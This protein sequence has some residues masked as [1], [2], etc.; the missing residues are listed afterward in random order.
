MASNETPQPTEEAVSVRDKE[1]W[2]LIEAMAADYRREGKSIKD[3]L[4]EDEQKLKEAI[5]SNRHIEL[6]DIATWNEYTTKRDVFAYAAGRYARALDDLRGDDELPDAPDFDQLEDEYRAA[7]NETAGEINE[8]LEAA[9]SGAFEEPELVLD[10]PLEGVPDTFELTAFASKGVEAKRRALAFHNE[11]KGS[12]SELGFTDFHS[13]PGYDDYLAKYGAYHD[14]LEQFS[15][16]DESHRG[17]TRQEINDFADSI[18]PL[19]EEAEAA[20]QAVNKE[21]VRR[22]E[23]EQVQHTVILEA[24]PKREALEQEYERISEQMSEAGI[25]TVAYGGQNLEGSQA[26][27]D[28]YSDYA[29]KLDEI[30]RVEVNVDT[31]TDNNL[32]NARRDVTKLESEYK[33][34]LQIIEDKIADAER[35]KIATD[36]PQ[37]G[38]PGNTW[39]MKDAVDPETAEAE[40]KKEFAQETIQGF[41][42]EISAMRKELQKLYG[43]ADAARNDDR[44]VAWVDRY[45]NPTRKKITALETANSEEAR[46]EIR[47]AIEELEREQRTLLRAVQEEQGAQKQEKERIETAKKTIEDLKTDA[48]EYA[49]KLENVEGLKELK[50]KFDTAADAVTLYLERYEAGRGTFEEIEGRIET[51]RGMYE[52]MERHVDDDIARSLTDAHEDRTRRERDE[53]EGEAEDSDGDPPEEDDD[54][55]RRRGGD[56]SHSSRSKGS[57]THVHIRNLHVNGREGGESGPITINIAN[58][59]EGMPRGEEGSRG[60]REAREVTVGAETFT[61]PGESHERTLESLRAWH[62]EILH[63]FARLDRDDPRWESLR[64]RMDELRDD[65]IPGFERAAGGDTPDEDAIRRHFS[66]AVNII[67][68]FKTELGI[69]GDGIPS[70]GTDAG[71]EDDGAETEPSEYGRFLEAL[72]GTAD[73]TEYLRRIREDMPEGTFQIEGNEFTRRSLYI[74]IF[75]VSEQI[76]YELL[77]NPELRNQGA[78][79]EKLAEY[80]VPDG[81]NIRQ[82]VA[83]HLIAECQ[84]Y[85]EVLLP[86]SHFITVRG[87]EMPYQVFLEQAKTN[88]QRILA[89]RA[90]ADAALTVPNIQTAF[91]EH[92]GVNQVDFAKAGVENLRQK[93]FD[94]LQYELVAETRT[95]ENINEMSLTLEEISTIEEFKLYIRSTAGIDGAY[96]SI[97]AIERDVRNAILEQAEPDRSHIESVASLAAMGDE[98]QRNKFT[99]L[100]AE[101][102]LGRERRNEIAEATSVFDLMGIVRRRFTEDTVTYNGAEYTGEQIA[103]AIRA[104]YDGLQSATL[105]DTSPL[106]PQIAQATDAIPDIDAMGIR[107]RFIELYMQQLGEAPPPHG[108]FRMANT[109]DVLYLARRTEWLYPNEPGI[110]DA[111]RQAFEAARTAQDASETPLSMEDISKLPEVQ[112]VPRKPG[113]Q[114]TAIRVIHRELGSGE[115]SLVSGMPV[116][117]ERIAAA[118]TFGD[119]DGALRGLDKRFSVQIGDNR[120]DKHEVSDAVTTTMNEVLARWRSTPDSRAHVTAADLG[121][122]SDFPELQAKVRD[123]LNA[124]FDV[125]AFDTVNLA[126]ESYALRIEDKKEAMEQERVAYLEKMKTHLEERHRQTSGNKLKLSE[127]TKFLLGFGFEK[128]YDDDL[129]AAKAKYRDT[130]NALAQAMSREAFV[131]SETTIEREL[132]E[133]E[134]LPPKEKYRI[135]KNENVL[136]TVELGVREKL[137]DMSP[138]MMSSRFRYVL[139]RRHVGPAKAEAWQAILT[140]REEEQNALAAYR[141]EIWSASDKDVEGKLSVKQWLKKFSVKTVGGAGAGTVVM[142]GGIPSAILLLGSVTGGYVI[143]AGAERFMRKYHRKQEEHIRS[144]NQFGVAMKNDQFDDMMRNLDRAEYNQRRARVWGMLAS[145]A[146]TAGFA[147]F[148]ARRSIAEQLAELDKVHLGIGSE[149]AANS[150]DEPDA[151][152]EDPDVEDPDE[153]DDVEPE[154]IVAL[155]PEAEPE[156]EPEPEPDAEEEQSGNGDDWKQAQEDRLAGARDYYASGPVEGTSAPEKENVRLDVWGSIDV[157]HAMT[158]DEIAEVRKTAELHAINDVDELLQVHI[159][160]ADTILD[161]PGSARHILDVLEYSSAKDGLIIKQ[162]NLDAIRGQMAFFDDTSNVER[163]CEGIEAILKQRGGADRWQFIGSEFPNAGQSIE[164][165]TARQLIEEINTLY[166]NQEYLEQQGLEVPD[167]SK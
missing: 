24:R 85:P 80:D 56:G 15:N 157:D 11:F 52:R 68:M 13:L 138:E 84:K 92:F 103:T 135:L 19:K 116:L 27:F 58:A 53:E 119:L 69:T 152:E 38:D 71:G 74:R 132:E 18:T 67:N 151:E 37:E 33:R 17:K 72:G 3:E 139:E 55:S 49:S 144:G 46:D 8:L 129:T 79:R 156:P 50:A 51:L 2:D 111:V 155:E 121:Q 145:I 130:Q 159:P 42:A 25:G 22:K 59:K 31:D 167:P 107:L 43:G 78:V 133:F 143:G 64:T 29:N 6:S 112:S 137:T 93:F 97:A 48:A 32:L 89:S 16:V 77:H 105:D 154:R 127:R 149:D 147:G 94:T 81:H 47:T 86:E 88:I 54:R 21:V 125:G 162:E 45:V 62:L 63:A 35:E 60:G 158:A 83:Q 70:W 136:R 100:L 96:E 99:D 163:L 41:T 109:R 23:L 12:L 34:Q 61:L 124:Q 76:L 65:C 134:A 146:A 4:T 20:M 30:L 91:I 82:K 102:Y 160:E 153:E 117:N 40:I 164:S 150:V 115:Y 44:Y 113:L 114:E 166:A 66:R 73:I 120:Y 26:Y 161:E 126:T 140:E 75:S 87:A 104:Q 108:E 106:E 101:R 123:I 148:G 1:F 10:K 95:L 131:G 141:K 118:T 165:A 57:G 36:G 39:E 122:L 128:K 9:E 5:R 28:A 98:A 142:L 14:A 7:F 90:G 110:G